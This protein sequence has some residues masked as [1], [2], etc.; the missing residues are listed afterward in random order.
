[1]NLLS[2]PHPL[3][4]AF[5]MAA[6]SGM[7]LLGLVSSRLGPGGIETA[8]LRNRSEFVGGN[9][10]KRRSTGY[11]DACTSPKDSVFHRDVD[12]PT[13]TIHSTRVYNDLAY[14]TEIERVLQVRR[15]SLFFTTSR[16]SK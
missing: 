9:K 11:E 14:K 15:L 4:Q 16:K 8:N 13:D 5:T 2:G 7:Y 12:G 3:P 1:M 6:L 10:R